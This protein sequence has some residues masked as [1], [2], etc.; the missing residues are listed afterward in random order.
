MKEKTYRAFVAFSGLVHRHFE[1]SFPAVCLGMRQILRY[2]L[3]MY[4][5]PNKI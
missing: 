4:E 1:F 2:L 3:G 5:I